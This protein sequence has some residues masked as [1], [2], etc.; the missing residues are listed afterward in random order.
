MLV[1]VVGVVSLL[2]LA[3]AVALVLK[4]ARRLVVEPTPAVYDPVEALDW[5][6][7]NVADNIAAT[8]T[9]DDVRQILDLQV[10]YLRIRAAS[11]N[12]SSTHTPGP[13][14][15][16]GPETVDYILDRATALGASFTSEQVYAVIETQLEYLRSI[17][18][19]GPPV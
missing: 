4:E 8:L 5:V 7:K 15:F 6:V 19:V 10:Q 12:G 2:V 17:G 11:S 16:G 14:I 18:A 9:I 13:I 3:I 1:V